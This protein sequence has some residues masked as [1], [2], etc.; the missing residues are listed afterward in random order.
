MVIYVV[1]AH[2]YF[3]LYQLNND[4]NPKLTTG[5]IH[6][7]SELTIDETYSWKFAFLPFFCFAFVEATIIHCIENV[8]Q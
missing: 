3:P 2:I 1:E 6:C 7:Q 8:S 4:R 5:L